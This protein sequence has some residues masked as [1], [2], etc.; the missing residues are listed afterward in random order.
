MAIKRGNPILG[1][2]EDQNFA[3]ALKLYDNKQYKKALKLV[4]ANLKKN[5]NH[6]ESLTLKGCINYHLGKSGSNASAATEK[7]DAEGY[8]VKGLSK[9]SSNYIV[10]HLAGI[11]YRANENYP[12]ACKWLKAAVDNGSPNKQLLRDLSVLQ[13]QTRDFKDLVATRQAYLDF[14]PAY[15]ANW[16]GVAI[17][18]DLNKNYKLAISTLEKIES[19]IKDHLQESD[20]YEQS[21][22][23]LYKNDLIFKTG[24]ISKALSQLE[25]DKPFVKDQLA[26]LEYK[27]KYLMILGNLDDASIIYRKLLQ[28]NPDKIDYYKNLE[29][30][31]KIAEKPLETRIKLYDNLKKLYPQAD[32]PAFL[33]LMFIP[34]THSAFTEKILN[35]I[36]SQLKRGV[37]AAFVN[38][39]PLLKNPKKLIIIEDLVTA[40][41]KSEIKNYNPTVEVWTLYFLS[42]LYL[43][44]NELDKADE[45]IDSALDHSPTLV[46][47]YI[48]KARVLKHKGDLLKASEIMN[49]GRKL[50]LQDRFIN[51]RATKYYLRSNQIDEAVNLIS[52]FTKLDD[53]AVNGCKDLHTM[54]ANW[55]LTE[56]AEAYSR[57]YKQYET[58][59]KNELS[60]PEADRDQELVND[61][62][63]QVD[64][65]KGLALKRFHAVVNIFNV[66]YNDQFDFHFYCLRKG[67]VR[68]YMKFLAWED[69]IHAT[70]IFVRVIKGL[71]NIYWEIYEQ[72]QKNKAS[73]QSGSGDDDGKNRKTG[74]KKNKKAKAQF[75]KQ[76]ESLIA[77]VQSEKD[78]QDPLG[79]LLLKDLVHNAHGD[80]VDNL[81]KLTAPLMTEAKNYQFT[82]EVSFELNLIKR[83]YVLCVQAIKNLNGLVNPTGEKKLARF[84]PMIQSLMN[85]IEKDDTVNAAIKQVV[86]KS[87][88]SSFPEFNTPEFEAVYNQ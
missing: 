21:E 28:R 18:A 70:P 43:Y 63:E 65:N 35:Y 57:L 4:D 55:F 87:L 36:L 39:K 53:K 15:R 61:L 31:L 22:C 2:K 41:Y 68:D 81:I 12:E 32:P 46:E 54:Q 74:N 72:Q 3:E 5:S 73:G 78:D 48:L 80:I 85:S 7:A 38:I 64:I 82:W 77:K 67:T 49:E 23:V 60:K 42:Q 34:S 10:D 26:Y 20:M 47:L 11:Y 76:K 50:D 71:T 8:I 6:A 66:F 79:S 84:K 51:S 83:K 25:T 56:S 30:C 86:E 88:V 16:T 75:L 1:S 29:I 33:P 19:L 59:L 14:Q 40:F 27:G 58:E 52:M 37:P 9:D 69:N 44:K 24:D 13:V 62:Q 17:A 45:F